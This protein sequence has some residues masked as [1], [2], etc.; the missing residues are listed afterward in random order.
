MACEQRFALGREPIRRLGTQ[1][2]S[3]QQQKVHSLSYVH[4]RNYIRCPRL[5]ANLVPRISHLPAPLG[6][7]PGGY[8]L[9]WALQVCAAQRVWFYSRFGHKLGIDFSHFA[10]ILFIN[11]VSRIDFYTLVFN[12]VLF[13]EEATFSSSLPSPIRALP[14]STPFNACQQKPFP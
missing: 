6:E 9:I 8:S 5:C 3:C 11:G 12:S 2:T 1:G 13:L 10:V 14:S 7:I 4:I